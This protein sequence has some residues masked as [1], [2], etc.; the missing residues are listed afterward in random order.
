MIDLEPG[1]SVSDLLDHL[2]VRYSALARVRNTVAVAVNQEYAA[3][4]APL[5][6]GDEV[7][8]IP[9]VAGG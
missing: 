5:S 3:P 9:P 6:D 7:A 4:D 1:S 2:Q 8:L